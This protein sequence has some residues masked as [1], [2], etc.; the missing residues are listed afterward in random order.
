MSSSSL[1]P[2]TLVWVNKERKDLQFFVL[3][4]LA[5]HIMQ[6]SL[7]YFSWEPSM[8]YKDFS[9]TICTSPPNKDG[10]F[11]IRTIPEWQ[12]SFLGK[13]QHVVVIPVTPESGLFPEDPWIVLGTQSDTY[14]VV[15]ADFV[16]LVGHSK[17]KPG[18]FYQ[19]LSS[20][21]KYL[22][23][24]VKELNKHEHCKSFNIWQLEW[25]MQLIQLMD[26]TNTSS[27][28]V[29]INHSSPGKKPILFVYSKA[30]ACVVL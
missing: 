27:D 9:I 1:T 10:K 7:D 2:S 20:N 23:K 16:H 12:T 30:S 8:I 14:R 4:L 24:V 28:H 22:V 19:K 29:L 18:Q 17:I 21:P 3:H 6:T 15:P 25:G 13:T 11:C 5:Y 26:S